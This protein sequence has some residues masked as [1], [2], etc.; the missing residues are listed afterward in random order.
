MSHGKYP[1]TCS[2]CARQDRD[3]KNT[4]QHRHGG[5]LKDN[6]NRI[7][8]SGFN[9]RY[10]RK[11]EIDDALEKAE[12]GR[13][14]AQKKIKEMAKVKLAPR[15]IEDC[16]LDSCIAGD[17]QKLVIDLVRLLKSDMAKRKPVQILVLQ[18]LVSKLL[19]N[20]NHHYA[21]LIK[22]FSA[23][24]KNELGPTNYSLLA[25]A[26]GLARATTA[27]SH[28]SE[29]RLDPGINNEALETAANLF[30]KLPVN[31]ASDG[32]RALRFLQAR[33]NA[34]GEVMLVGQGWDPNV[35]RW[36]LQEVPLPRKDA[37]KGDKDDF[38]ALKRYIDNVIEHDSL[39]K[40][41]S[42][43]NLNCLTS[44]EQPSI[45]YCLWPTKDK[46]YTG[47]HLLNY[48]QEL[49]RLCYYNEKGEV[50][51][52][53]IHL[54]GYSTDSAGFSLS[55]A[56][57]LMTP[58]AEDIANGVR[59]LGLGVEDEKFMSPYYWF[60]PAI[61]FLDYDHEQRLF[62]KNLKYETRELTFWKEEDSTT[63]M[64]SIQHLKD[65]RQR[66]QEKG[67]DSGLKATDL[68]LIYFCDQNSDACER[69]F[70][71]RI[72][73][74][75]DTH[76]NGSQGTSLYIRSVFHLI[77][78]FRK[79]DFGSP[80]DVQKSVSCGITILRLWRK[81]VEL[82]KRLLHSKPGAKKI[83]AN[84]G[85]YITRGCY[86]TAEVLFAAA[87]L[88]QLAMFLHFPNEA[89][90]WASPHNS[91]TKTTE[92]IISELQGK[93]TE[94]QSLDSQPTFGDMLDKS[95]KVQF[96]LNAKRRIAAAGINVKSSSKRKQMAFAF[97]P[98]GR[99]RESAGL[100]EF[101]SYTA[102]R[103][104]QKKAHH[105]GVRDG[106]DLFEKYMPRSCVDLLK[107]N[108]SWD[109]PYKFNHPSDLQ[110][111]DGDLPE[112]YNKLDLDVSAGSLVEDIALE[113]S[114]DQDE[115]DCVT[116]STD[117]LLD[118]EQED[119]E[120]E[121]DADSKSE[122]WMISKME[123]GKL[124][125]IHISQAIKILLPREYI[126]R[127]RQ[128]RHWAAKYLPGKEPLN[129]EHD[130]FVFGNVALKRKKEGVNTFLISRV[131]RIESIKDGAEV[132]SFKLKNSPQVRLRCALYARVTCDD[133]DDEYQVG[134]EIVLTPWR[135]PSGI[136]GPVQLLPIAEKP[137]GYLLHEE[138]KKWLKS[139]GYVPFDENINKREEVAEIS[140]HEQE[141]EEGF[142]E[143]EDVLE[144][145]LCKDMT[146]QFHVRFKGYG[147]E[148]DMWLPASA[149]NRSVAFESTSRFGRKRK[150]RTDETS[151]LLNTSKDETCRE[152]QRS[153]K[154]MK[155]GENTKT[156]NDKAHNSQADRES[157]PPLKH[158]SSKRKG[159]QELP[160][161]KEKKTNVA[162]GKGF[163][164]SLLNSQGGKI[165]ESE[166][167]D[168]SPDHASEEEYAHHSHADR[169]STPLFKDSLSKRKGQKAL[170]KKKGENI[171]KG[172]HF[173]QSCPD[174]QGGKINENESMDKSSDH[175]ITLSSD[176][177]NEELMKTPSF[178]YDVRY[179]TL[180]DLR[181]R[182]D[183]FATPR[184]Q[185]AKAELPTVDRGIQHY[186]IKSFTSKNN[187][188]PQDPLAVDRVP[189]MS[190]L[191]QSMEALREIVNKK[192]RQKRND[193]V[194]EYQ[195]YGCFT[196]EGLRILSRYNTIR[197]VARQVPEEIRWMTT[198]F[199]TFPEMDRTLVAGALLDRWNTSGNL[200]VDFKGYKIT[201]Q[202]LSVL[203]C[204][205]YLNDEV[206]NL[207]IIKYCEE[208][209]KRR[210]G[211]VFTMLPS[212]VTSL[213]GTNAIH[214]VC[215]NVDMSKVDIVFLPMHL[216]GCHWGLA[217]FYVK[218]QE[219]QF[220]DGYHCP[221]TNEMESTINGIL[222]T[223]H[224]ATSLPC[225]EPSCWSGVQRFKIPMPDQPAVSASFL[226]GT[227][228]CGVGVLCCVRDICNGFREAFT[229]TFD[230][231]PHLRAQLMVEL[232]K[233]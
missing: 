183:N 47:K 178:S 55:A 133:A 109:F 49:R 196:L 179:W 33:K 112:N 77:Q 43:H 14:S 23:L 161:K 7:G 50:R 83:P 15:E 141:L 86:L 28:G 123:Q 194:I 210:Q 92:R 131:E 223:F 31:E 170:S 100:H 160:K 177:E 163:R 1:F 188:K 97:K 190:V 118:L 182:D 211:E 202:D 85:H 200:L 72:A 36:N 134:D 159:Q 75:L 138:S 193:Y 146:Y 195:H 18:N 56:V 207:L 139:V 145:R 81:V 12:Y 124:S 30:K 73:D 11:G 119:L 162:K 71:E 54:L 66:C 226:N 122:K 34:N 53:P 69:L 150:H 228:S 116:T 201:S 61:C 110:L 132:L 98:C 52:E 215:A 231:A 166:T 205:R 88:H 41:V 38:T 125:N 63:R 136:L 206:M 22:D 172:K 64:A 9:K 37:K 187:V 220:D 214:Q 204:E 5:S 35:Q 4:L 155:D 174:S 79:P 44:M 29:T 87:T 213:F 20:N 203:C 117:S 144:R 32:A 42:I 48:W 191:D 107:E 93:T 89:E 154:R 68:I 104:M 103:E 113:L 91:G 233:A 74:L 221:I 27:A 129:P 65:L 10:A 192:A 62:L 16:L 24:F 158:S 198:A 140:S 82:Q 186:S 148:D 40:T 106:Q 130:I 152:T 120:Q 147:P 70:T 114:K 128:K 232:L 212:Y 173:R 57:H 209:N 199:E 137:G 39:A 51:E 218:K 105:E 127:C 3:L 165:T 151:L 225:F 58:R 157:T 219:V 227:G 180:E 94:L 230:D 25:E 6:K 115:D 26:F 229:W 80:F 143:V 46:G 108:D 67:L 111:C 95:G 19:K 17:E 216:H 101:T 96:N 153:S 189:P 84:R 126:A 208:A 175:A 78:P 59:Y 121:L 171:A 76:V 156:K 176:E 21:S 99:P 167:M 142:Y 2:N 184:R 222:R 197:S 169:E 185:L 135:S 164:Q 60:L 149:F 224:Q 168:K 45:I 90:A 217:V 13:R 8:L 102:F 181:C